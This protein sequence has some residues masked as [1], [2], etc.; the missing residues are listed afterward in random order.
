M[1]RSETFARARTSFGL[2]VLLGA[3]TG[4][5]FADGILVLTDAIE[6]LPTAR[7]AEYFRDTEG[8]MTFENI[9]ALPEK[10]WKTTGA[11]ALNFGYSRDAIWIKLR[12]SN[13]SKE[14]GWLLK[15][16]YTSLDHVIL[17]KP[18]DDGYDVSETGRLFPFD[19]REVDVRDFVFN[20]GLKRGDSGTFYYRVESE[21]SLNCEST[22]W[23]PE[24]FNRKLDQELLFGGLFYGIM[25][26]MTLYNFSI[27]VSMG[28]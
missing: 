27:Y 21:T 7:Y 22:I 6:S 3:A 1:R 28:D 23:K 2:L 13:Q 18:V 16:E 19:H 5:V 10:Q 12:L 11:H 8:S 26:I 9:R 24:R 14:E 15:S 4:P 20:L 25:L 17:F